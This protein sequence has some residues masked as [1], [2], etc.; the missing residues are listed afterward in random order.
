MGATTCI[1]QAKDLNPPS[2]MAFV[3]GDSG[4][5]W[6]ELPG[7]WTYASTFDS[8]IANRQFS[9]SAEGDSVTVNCNQDGCARAE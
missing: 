5:R 8:D 3:C 1:F 2:T 4:V 9:F 7:A 6:P